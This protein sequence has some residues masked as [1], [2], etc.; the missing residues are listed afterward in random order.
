MINRDNWKD[1]QSFLSHQQNVLQNSS[2]TISGY[3]KYLRHL[4]EWADTVSLEK[5]RGIEPTFPVYLRAIIA[6]PTGRPLMPATFAKCLQQVRIFF[7]FARHAWPSRYKSISES[8]IATLQPSRERGVQSRLKQHAHYSIEDVQKIAS[9]YPTAETLREKREIAAACFLFL[10]AARADAFFSFPI[11]CIDLSAMTVMQLPEKGVR[12][13]NHK[14]AITHLLNC[15]ELLDVVTDW[16][17]LVRTNLDVNDLWFPVLN[18]AGDQFERGKKGHR[19][20]VS[21]FAQNLKVLCKLAGVTYLSPHKLRHGHA[22]YALK[23]V[24]D[25]AGL[26]AVSQNLMHESVTITDAVYGGLS[27]EDI[28]EVYSKI[29]GPKNEKQSSTQLDPKAMQEL[30][31]NPAFLAFMEAMK[32]KK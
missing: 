23:G 13:K 31:S 14:A 19:N 26:K 7:T 11:S 4:L 5:A 2:F 25:M 9:F 29:G 10:S 27:V 20:R 3:R 21:N 17:Q 18:R 24:E 1:V 15:K 12:T 30:F 32:E 8:W 6:E 16:D 28:S 22:V